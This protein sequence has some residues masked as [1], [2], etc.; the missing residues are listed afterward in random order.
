MSNIV[1]NWTDG[2]DKDFGEFY[3]LKIKLESLDTKEQFFRQ[4]R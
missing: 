2:S 1:F 4:E 3:K